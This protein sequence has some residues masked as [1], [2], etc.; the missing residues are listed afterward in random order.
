MLLLARAR[1]LTP[2]SLWYRNEGVAVEQSGHA[3]ADG[4]GTPSAGSPISVAVWSYHSPRRWL[5]TQRYMPAMFSV[6]MVSKAV[7]C[8]TSS[9][10]F[11]LR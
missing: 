7:Q 3:I 8:L 1:V 6:C 9:L 10:N 4:L 5:D 2:I 11:T